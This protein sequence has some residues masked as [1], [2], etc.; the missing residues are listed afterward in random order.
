MAISGSKEARDG[1]ADKVQPQG[2]ADQPASIDREEGT[3]QDFAVHRRALRAGQWPDTAGTGKWGQ[4]G[5]QGLAT[6]NMNRVRGAAAVGAALI[7]AASL[8]ACARPVGDLGRAAPSV[9]HDEIMPA[10]GAVRASRDGEPVSRFNQTDEERE[11]HDRVW[12]FLVAPHTHDWFYDTAVEHQRTRLASRVDV[13]FLADR[14]YA[15]LRSQAYASSR[16]RYRKIA[17]DIAADIATIPQTFAAICRVVEIDRQRAIAVAN[18]ALG[19]ADGASQVAARKWENDETIDWFTRA[20]AY[21]HTSYSV[22]LERLLVETPHEEARAVDAQLARMA[23][24]VQRAALGDFCL[25]GTG[26]AVFK[27]VAIPSRFEM[28]GHLGE[29]QIRK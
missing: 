8:G 4:T 25:T 18:V 27:D 10:M 23:P 1:Y 29:P 21:R 11:M 12:R 3:S 20:L 24:Y 5:T 9:L 19:E 6:L 14:Y 28:G 26:G 17:D 16:V 2:D 13:T 7:V 15:L 22:A